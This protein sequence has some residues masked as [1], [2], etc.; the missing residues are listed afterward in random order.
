MDGMGFGTNINRWCEPLN[1]ANR[2]SKNSF[3][4]RERA[5][6]LPARFRTEKICFKW[7]NRSWFL[8]F[9]RFIFAETFL[10]SDFYLG[11]R[12]RCT[13]VRR[14]FVSGLVGHVLPCC[15]HPSF[16]GGTKEIDFKKTAL[17]LAVNCCSQISRDESHRPH[18]WEWYIL[19]TCPIKIH[20]SCS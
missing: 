12:E 6:E 13:D 17:R 3:H 11:G 1:G 7:L 4:E 10:D 20:H 5:K 15:F 16:S 2:V 9:Q 8:C 18:P 14:F 19:I